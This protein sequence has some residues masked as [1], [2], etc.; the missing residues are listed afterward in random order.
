MELELT[1]TE[2]FKIIHTEL[3]L[4]EIRNSLEMLGAKDRKL[5]LVKLDNDKLSLIEEK[6]TENEGK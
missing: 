5:E 2:L 6:V 4:L 3:L 1:V